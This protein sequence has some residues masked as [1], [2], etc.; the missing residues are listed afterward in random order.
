MSAAL[1]DSAGQALA[2]SMGLQQSWS[3]YRKGRMVRTQMTLQKSGKEEPA[4]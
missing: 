4:A 2:E 1:E 3:R